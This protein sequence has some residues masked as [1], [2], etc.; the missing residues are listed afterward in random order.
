MAG[1]GVELV[2]KGLAMLG[3]MNT[4]DDFAAVM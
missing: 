2:G 3:S 4:G 1:K